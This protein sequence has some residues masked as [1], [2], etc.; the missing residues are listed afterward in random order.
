MITSAHEFIALRSS[1]DVEQQKRAAYE[2]A[3]EEV[4]LDIV[5]QY[6]DL[7]FWVAQNKTVPLG[8]LH[9]LAKDDDPRVRWMVAQKRT[10]DAATLAAMSNDKDDSVRL[11]VASHANTSREILEQLV[12]DPWT[13]IATI[14]RKRLGIHER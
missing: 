13:E 10:L 5:I 4:W 6:P 9:I 11:S 7:R 14:A 3:T 2:S 12:N 8:V 1:D